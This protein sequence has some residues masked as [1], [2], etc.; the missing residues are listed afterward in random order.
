MVLVEPL[1]IPIF[2]DRQSPVFVEI[3]TIIRIVRREIERLLKEAMD[4]RMVE[5]ERRTVGGRDGGGEETGGEVGGIPKNCPR[6]RCISS[7]IAHSNKGEAGELVELVTSS[8]AT[9]F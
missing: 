8:D 2:A 6:H 1:L 5:K 3:P 7:K 4:E 9:S